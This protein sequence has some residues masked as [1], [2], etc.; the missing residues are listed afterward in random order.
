MGDDKA[1]TLLGLLG[2]DV[3]NG[4]LGHDK[5][6]GYLGHDTLIGGKDNDWLEGGFGN[7]IY[8]YTKGDG[9]DTIK[10]IGGLDILKITN[11]TLSD[12]GFVKQGKNLFIDTNLND[13]STNE[14]ILIENYFQQSL[15]DMMTGRTPTPTIERLYV[16]DKLVSHHEIDKLTQIL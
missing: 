6:Y 7:D 2:D 9:K 13:N 5:L 8:L 14:G 1:N 12:L 10:D 11:L 4:G 3:L 16:D 15:I